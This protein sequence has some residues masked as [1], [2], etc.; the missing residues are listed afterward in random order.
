MNSEKPKKRNRLP[1]AI[2]EASLAK[3]HGSACAQIFRAIARA[4]G[5][6]DVGG[7][8]PLDLSGLSAEER[9]AVEKIYLGE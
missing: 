4:G 6:G 8:Q 2:T 5:F 3:T 1:R 9:A 7:N